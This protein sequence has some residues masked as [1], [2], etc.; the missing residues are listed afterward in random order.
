MIGYLNGVRVV[1]TINIKTFLGKVLSLIFSY[2]SGLA[3]G[4]EGEEKGFWL[5]NR[6]WSIFRL[7]FR[8]YDSPWRNCGR[9]YGPSEE[10]NAADLPSTYIVFAIQKRSGPTR[11][12][13]FW[14][15]IRSVIALSSL[16][17]LPFLDTVNWLCEK[18]YKN[19]CCSSF[20]G[21]YRRASFLLG[22]GIILLEQTVDMANIFLL[23]DICLHGCL[24]NE[25]SWC[26]R[27]WFRYVLGVPV[28]GE[29]YL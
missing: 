12:H 24:A 11:F 25:R 9:R 3:I 13:I 7:F 22:R 23:H 16:F 26:E 10:P 8:S 1:H 2:A 28:R 20:R 19:R 29:K 15:R 18:L 5:A 4:P 21:A 6:I 27:I 17:V 14:C